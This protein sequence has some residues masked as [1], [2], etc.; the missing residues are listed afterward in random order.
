MLLF[1]PQQAEVLR[2]NARSRNTQR[3]ILKVAE[4]QFPALAR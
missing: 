2:A 4:V 1:T 3:E